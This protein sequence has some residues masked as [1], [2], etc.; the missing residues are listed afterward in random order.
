MHLEFSGKVATLC[1]AGLEGLLQQSESVGSPVLPAGIEGEDSR[2][3]DGRGGIAGFHTQ[4]RRA[5]ACC[6]KAVCGALSFRGGA[7]RAWLSGARNVAR[8]GEVSCLCMCPLD[9]T[10]GGA[11]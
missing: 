9:F 11:R 5:L 2:Y 3:S 8:P 10:K 7:G 4:D 6:L 1:P